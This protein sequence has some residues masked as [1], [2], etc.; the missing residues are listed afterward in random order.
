MIMSDAKTE[1]LNGVRPS[2]RVRR[3][4]DDLGHRV[5]TYI[6]STQCQYL[7]LETLTKIPDG[8]AVNCRWGNAYD[9]AYVA[10]GVWYLVWDDKT[11]PTPDGVQVRRGLYAKQCG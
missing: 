6:R 3:I 8:L 5:P 4:R 11:M 7:P 9:R 2:E 1:S 10:D